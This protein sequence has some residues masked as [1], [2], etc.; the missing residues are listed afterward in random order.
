[1]VFKYYLVIKIFFSIYLFDLFQ[2]LAGAIAVVGVGA[3]IYNDNLS[4][5]NRLKDEDALLAARVK[6]L[7]SDG[8]LAALATRV[9]TVESSSSSATTQ[10]A[11]NCAKVLENHLKVS[12]LLFGHKLQS[13]TP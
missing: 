8:G 10:A 9:S 13:L 7:E 6:A 1:M 3:I 4:N 2:L 11:A 5:T 12:I